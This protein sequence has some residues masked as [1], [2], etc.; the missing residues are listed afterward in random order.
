MGGQARNGKRVCG[1]PSEPAA[2]CVTISAGASMTS[3]LESLKDLVD[4]DY[5]FTPA[6]NVLQLKHTIVSGSESRRSGRVVRFR[7]RFADRIAANL[8]TAGGLVLLV[9]APTVPYRALLEIAPNGFVHLYPGLRRLV[10]R[11]STPAP[12]AAR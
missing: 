7:W 10:P 9:E 12:P 4:L 2:D 8:R 3:L 11:R 6:T 1:R 5:G